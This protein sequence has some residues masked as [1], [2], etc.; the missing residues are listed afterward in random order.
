MRLQPPQSA[1][2]TTLSEA[3]SS[4]TYPYV[5]HGDSEHTLQSLASGIADLCESNLVQYTLGD[6][7]V[8]FLVDSSKHTV[9]LNVPAFK[10]SEEDR[11]AFVSGQ[12]A[13]NNGLWYD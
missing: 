2:V 5:I 13:F 11:L 1:F 10:G 3:A 6:S 9:V 7:A 4:R 12:G 8:P